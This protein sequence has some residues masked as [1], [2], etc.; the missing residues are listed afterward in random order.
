MA[1]QRDENSP[2]CDDHVLPASVPSAF[3]FSEGYNSRVEKW[4]LLSLL[5]STKTHGD[6]L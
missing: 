6:A 4:D 3:S 1:E 2:L 5:Y